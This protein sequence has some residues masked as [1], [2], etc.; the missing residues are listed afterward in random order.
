MGDRHDQL[1]FAKA[2]AYAIVAIERLPEKWQA[3]DDLAEMKALLD[4][5][6][7]KLVQVFMISARSH[8]ERRELDS[9]SEELKLVDRDADIVP[10]R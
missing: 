1:T 10:I 5:C 8:L 7:P 2:L 6:D 3:F 9:N 4:R